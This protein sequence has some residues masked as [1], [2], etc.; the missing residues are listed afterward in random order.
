MVDGAAI[1]TKD[2]SGIRFRTG[3]S[4][5]LQELLGGNASFG[6][7]IGNA[8]M[9]TKNGIITAPT[10]DITDGSVVT[11]E[12]TKWYSDIYYH[13]AM[14]GIPDNANAYQVQLAGR[15]YVTVTYADGG[16]ATFYTDFDENNVRSMYDIAV[17]L[18]AMHNDEVNYPEEQYRLTGDAYTV[19]TYIINTVENAK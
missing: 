15:G 4:V 17:K 11:V 7:L 9:L 1:R 10:L 19:V 12:Q 18:M 6:T 13:A 2:G 8:A 14:V 3:V 16:S 5:E